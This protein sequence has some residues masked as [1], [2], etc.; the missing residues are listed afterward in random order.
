MVE[1]IEPTSGKDIAQLGK[2]L[3]PLSTPA[4]DASAAIRPNVLPLVDYE[5]IHVPA[6]AEAREALLETVSVDENGV[7]HCIGEKEGVETM[8]VA[9][10]IGD[11]QNASVVPLV[12]AEDGVL[13]LQLPSDKPSRIGFFVGY[14]ADSTLS[15]VLRNG[16]YPGIPLTIQS[17]DDS[18]TGEVMY[19][20]GGMKP[21]E[22]DQ[23]KWAEQIDLH[24][25]GFDPDTCGGMFNKNHRPNP[26]SDTW[27]ESP[28]VI[29]PDD[30]AEMLPGFDRA[31]VRTNEFQILFYKTHE[32][33]PL[34]AFNL[35]DLGNRGGH[36]QDTL[37]YE[38]RLSTLG[39]GGKT[40]GLGLGF[41]NAV[42]REAQTRGIKVESLQG[43]F[44]IRAVPAVASEG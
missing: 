10:R 28:L 22:V 9:V 16:L 37:S 2:G 26:T 33:E 27:H 43:A 36:R 24:K 25:L 29:L 35:H 4:V 41:G 38:G 8:V 14:S 11:E 21:D 31:R 1:K 42:N 32:V 18:K 40:K 44:R 30:Q 34:P 13:Q 15:G 17:R 23:R 20:L 12:Q 3:I 5:L 39:L 7:A 6:E 19:G